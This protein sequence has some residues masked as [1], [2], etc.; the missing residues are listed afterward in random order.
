MGRA[1]K[2]STYEAFV[3][4]ERLLTDHAITF[5]ADD[6]ALIVQKWLVVNE[7]GHPTEQ[8][9]SELYVSPLLDGH[10]RV[11]G[12]L[13]QEDSMEFLA[14]LDVV[15][16]ELWRQDQAD[17]KE[18]GTTPKTPAQLRAEALVEIARRSSVAGDRDSDVAETTETA[19]SIRR[20]PRRSQ[21]LVIVDPAALGR[22]G[23]RHRRAR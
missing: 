12:E 9:P 2:P 19:V 3:R 16:D 7:P 5:D 4:D 10:H 22:R 1:V 18:L 13:D 20:R 17:V 8:G 6:F 14:E 21:M 15:Y 11:D 23:D